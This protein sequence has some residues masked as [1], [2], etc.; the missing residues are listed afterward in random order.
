MGALSPRAKA[1]HEGACERGLLVA[2]AVLGLACHAAEGAPGGWAPTVPDSPALQAAPGVP[3]AG[4]PATRAGATSDAQDPTMTERAWSLQSSYEFVLGHTDF[5]LGR[6]RF[7]DSVTTV[8]LI[9]TFDLVRPIGEEWKLIPF[10]GLGMGWLV[11]ADQ[12]VVILTSGVRAEWSRNLSEDLEVLVF[13]RLRYDANLNRAD[14]LLG[15]W[16]R[17]DLALELRRTFG[18]SG[19]PVRIQGGVYAQGFWYFDDI[20]FDVDGLAPDSVDG[21]LEFGISLGTQEPVELLG[22]TLPRT[23]LGFATGDGLQAYVLRFGAL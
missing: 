3:V 4:A 12:E 18:E 22:I 8:A 1:V 6:G 23:Y 21:Q 13:P 15:D 7:L 17:G 11:D 9:P 20:D 19:Q 16:G 2:A 14:G 10:I 5:E